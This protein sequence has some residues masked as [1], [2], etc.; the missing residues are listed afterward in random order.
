MNKHRFDFDGREVE[1][2]NWAVATRLLTGGVRMIVAVDHTIDAQRPLA[3]PPA[4]RR[5]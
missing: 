3:L 4:N 5:R 2:L 1:A